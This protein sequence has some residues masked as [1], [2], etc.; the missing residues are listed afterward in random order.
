MKKVLIALVMLAMMM[1]IPALAEKSDNPKSDKKKQGKQKPAPA[2]VAKA[3]K[4]VAPDVEK[5]RMDMEKWRVE[6]DMKDHENQL[7]F[8]AQMRGLQLE[9][10]KAEIRKKN[11]PAVAPASVVE[12]RGCEG[13][14][15]RHCMKEGGFWIFV[16][17]ANLLMGIWVYQDTRRRE[18][19]SGIWI[20]ITLMTGFFGALVYAV[21]RLGDN[22]RPPNSP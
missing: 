21:I 20:I 14:G 13:G 7:G 12:K 22:N 9:E 11:Q 3:G 10:K 16:G 19:S 4:D 2:Q 17:I 1:S 8:Q 6:L 15:R 5:W 18:S